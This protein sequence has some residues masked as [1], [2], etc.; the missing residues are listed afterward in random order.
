MLRFLLLLLL[1]SIPLGGGEC[2]K[3]KCCYYASLARRRKE[4]NQSSLTDGLVL[5]VGPLKGR[6]YD[7]SIIAKKSSPP[8]EGV[9]IAGWESFFVF[10][11]K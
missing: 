11:T 8:E 4:R 3:C 6:R 7:Y 5:P 10:T 1:G 2:T 9:C